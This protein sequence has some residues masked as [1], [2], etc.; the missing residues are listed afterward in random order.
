MLKHHFAR[1]AAAA[2]TLV[3]LVFQPVRAD[4]AG[5]APGTS[6]SAGG[7]EVASDS[8]NKKGW[9][10]GARVSYWFSSIDG[11][12]RVDGNGIQGTTIDLKND[13]GV[14][15]AYMGYVEAYGQFGRHHLMASYVHADYSGST[16]IPRTL[17][18]KG[19]TYPAG[20][21]VEAELTFKVMNFEYQYDFLRLENVLA[22][23]SVGV[24]GKIM[25]IEGETS[26]QAPTLGLYG[27]GS[28]YAPIPMLGI[29]AQLSILENLLG[30]RG[31][32]TGSNFSGNTFYEADAA[33]SLTPLSFIELSC[34]YRIIKY[35]Y[36]K[37]ALIFNITMSGPYVGLALRY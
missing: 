9:E 31:K 24:I 25:Y 5:D 2:I 17:I 1:L 7:R 23:M 4:A 12:L 19:Q 15:N 21:L 36:E 33:F 30:L 10:S 16:N 13:L 34:G 32:V 26:S 28:F 3:V 20:S 29:G 6:D 27:Q 37:D 14:S 18:F 35:D 8:S 22:G 11:D